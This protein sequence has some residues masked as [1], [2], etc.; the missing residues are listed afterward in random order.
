MDCQSY[1]KYRP[2]E[3]TDDTVIVFTYKVVINKVDENNK[4][5]DG[6]EFTHIQFNG[7]RKLLDKQGIGITISD[8]ARKML[9]K[10]T[11]RI[12]F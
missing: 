1:T 9:E 3:T 2:N 5:L 8:D 11:L 6:A 4:A 10:S 7:V 12:S